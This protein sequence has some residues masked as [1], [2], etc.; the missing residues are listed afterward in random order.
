MNDGKQT[1][2]N[3]KIRLI[4]YTNSH[5]YKFDIYEEIEST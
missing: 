4:E 2:E 5:E 3:Q 1:T